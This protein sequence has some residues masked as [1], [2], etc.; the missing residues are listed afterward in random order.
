MTNLAD[1]VSPSCFGPVTAPPGYD[2]RNHAT[3]TL[4]V[5]L[6]SDSPSRR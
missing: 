2:V 5:C 3:D 6:S 1:S 4:M